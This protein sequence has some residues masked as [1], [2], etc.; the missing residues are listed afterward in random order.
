MGEGSLFTLVEIIFE[1]DFLIEKEHLNIFSSGNKG[2][3]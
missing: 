3:C 1:F 2:A